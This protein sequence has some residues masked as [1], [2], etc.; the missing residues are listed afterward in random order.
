MGLY[1]GEIVSYNIKRS[2]TFINKI[3]LCF[4]EDI[5]ASATAKLAG[6]NRRLTP[7][8]MISDIKY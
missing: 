5:T 2:Q 3:I 8:S 1:N 6:V 4:C 7:V